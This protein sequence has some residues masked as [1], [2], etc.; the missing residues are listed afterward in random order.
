MK[1]F[2]RARGM[3][4][5]FLGV[6]AIFMFSGCYFIRANVTG[7]ICLQAGDG[8]C[9]PIPS[10]QVDLFSSKGDKVDSTSSDMQ[11]SFVFPTKVNSGT[12]TLK[13]IGGPFGMTFEPWEKTMRVYKAIHRVQIILHMKAPT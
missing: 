12:Y 3:V 5:V 1:R 4:L 7:K 13:V 8:P 6:L 9:S 2:R 10:V 11:G